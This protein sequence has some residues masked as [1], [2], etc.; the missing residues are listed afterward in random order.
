VDLAAQKQL[1]ALNSTQNTQKIKKTP[2]NEKLFDKPM[3]LV[4]HLSSTAKIF[5]SQ[6]LTG[7]VFETNIL[8]YGSWGNPF[9]I[10]P[11]ITPERIWKLALLRTLSDYRGLSPGGYLQGVISRT[12]IYIDRNKKIYLTRV[13]NLETHRPTYAD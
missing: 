10:L 6:L 12:L 2:L 4:N 7:R 1:L 3:S 8:I 5:K 11:E 13:Y 9:E